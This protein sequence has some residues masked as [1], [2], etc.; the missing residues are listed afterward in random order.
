MLRA[1]VDADQRPGVV[2]VGMAGRTGGEGCAHRRRLFKDAPRFL[3]V[4]GTFPASPRVYSAFAT[5]FSVEGATR[6]P[7]LY[8]YLKVYQLGTVP[9]STIVAGPTEGP[10]LSDTHHTCIRRKITP[11]SHNE[12]TRCHRAVFGPLSVRADMSR[13][14]PVDLRLVGRRWVSLALLDAPYSVVLTGF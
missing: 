6:C 7:R 11:G 2:R 1:R 5:A 14:A 4:V 13:T 8:A 12:L 10:A 9:G 3:L